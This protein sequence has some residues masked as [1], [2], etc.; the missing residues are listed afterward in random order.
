M[1]GGFDSGSIKVKSEESIVMLLTYF[2]SKVPAR[3][4]ESTIVKAFRVK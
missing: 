3:P 1:T 2:I 4:P